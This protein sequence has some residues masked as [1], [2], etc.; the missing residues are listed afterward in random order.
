M[1]MLITSRSDSEK[2]RLAPGDLQVWS[3]APSVNAARL[4]KV[5]QLAEFKVTFTGC[6]GRYSQLFHSFCG[7]RKRVIKLA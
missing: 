3:R 5:L 6:G 2:P 1:L 4:C 7:K